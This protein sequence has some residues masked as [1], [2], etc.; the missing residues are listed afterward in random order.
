MFPKIDYFEK[1]NAFLAY[2]SEWG[3][4]GELNK[5]KQTLFVVLNT[6]FLQSRVVLLKTFGKAYAQKHKYAAQC[7]YYEFPIE[8]PWV[9]NSFLFYSGA[10]YPV[11]KLPWISHSPFGQEFND[12]NSHYTGQTGRI[13]SKCIHEHQLADR[14]YN[15]NSLI[16]QHLD[17]DLTIVSNG[18]L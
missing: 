14:R 8:I 15:E 11:S 3:W 6:G 10:S 9:I 17:T 13:L 12:C 1:E 5:Y 7:T 2:K 16:S 4:D 18:K